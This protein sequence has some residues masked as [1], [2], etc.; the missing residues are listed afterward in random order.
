MGDQG[1]LRRL[2]TEFR[3]F[4]LIGDTTWCEGR[5][6]HKYKE[7]A[8]DDEV[9]TGAVDVELWSRDQRNE[10]TTLGA[11]TVLLPLRN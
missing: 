9:Q 7:V 8:D 2:R 4:N 10:V 5:V 3:R 1:F 11:A 6:V